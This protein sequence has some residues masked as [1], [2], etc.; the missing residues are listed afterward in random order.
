MSRKVHLILNGK[1]ADND[2]LR[3]AVTR[4]REAGHHVEVRVTWEKEDARRF[5]LEADKADLLI[6]AGGDGTLNEV[7]HGLM[8][9]SI[10]ARPILGVVPL[11]TAND[12]ATGCGLPGDL[13]KALALCME[14]DAVPIDVGRANERWFLNAASAGFGAQ[15]TATT[16]PDLKRL[17]GSAAYAVMG[18]VL[19]INVHQ[20]HGRVTLPGRKITGS[21][22]VAIIGN[23]R[24]TGGGVQVTPR[25]F[26]D[27]GLL[28]VLVI[29]QIPA[30]ALLTAAREL[31]QLSPDGEYISYW[32][33]PWIEVY[34]EEMIP[35]NLDGEPMEFSSVRYEAVPRAIRLIVPPNCP[36]LST[37]QGQRADPAVG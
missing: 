26:I 8:D 16:S 5:V 28:D 34:S 32:Q 15:V 20:Y 17:L 12:F 1:V 13:E 35:V 30:T 37:T 18:A 27:D 14:G 7:V 19:A 33:T 23:G 21:G 3:A 25:A 22:P 10:D 11:G 31:Q 2:V 29:R 4:Q 9:L 36:L 6:A 24:Q